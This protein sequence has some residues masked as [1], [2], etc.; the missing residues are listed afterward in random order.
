MSKKFIFV[1][2]VWILSHLPIGAKPMERN[3]F[4]RLF[5]NARFYSETFLREKVFLHFDNTSYY[6]GDSIWIK[7]YVVNACNDSLS[8]I[9]KPLYVELLDQ[10]GNV[11]DRRI[12]KLS[13][14]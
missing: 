9:S 3:L 6:Q 4:A 13:N 1:I 7:A 10:L 5:D 8:K 11:V 12:V 2:I 14:G